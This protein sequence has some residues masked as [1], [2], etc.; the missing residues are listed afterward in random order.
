MNYRTVSREEFLLY[1][2]CMD[3]NGDE[4]KAEAALKEVEAKL[5]NKEYEYAIPAL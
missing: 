4:G 2:A 1:S 5:G 3:Y